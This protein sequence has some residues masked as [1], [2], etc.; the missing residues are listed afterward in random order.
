MSRP[1][2]KELYLE[3]MGKI[4][5]RDRRLESQKTEIRELREVARSFFCKHVEPLLMAGHRTLIESEAI[6]MKYTMLMY[7]RFD[8]GS[9][10][11]GITSL[12]W[13]GDEIKVARNVARLKT[14]ID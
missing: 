5:E 9:M 11:E 2:Y 8:D 13:Q 4:R 3:A 10:P 7:R 6:A 1:K 14:K 12:W